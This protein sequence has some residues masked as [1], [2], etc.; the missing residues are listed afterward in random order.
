M[1]IVDGGATTVEE[2]TDVV[3]EPKPAKDVRES[4]GIDP[5]KIGFGDEKRNVRGNAV[6][7]PDFHD[8]GDEFGFVVKI[9]PLNCAGRKGIVLE[10]EESE[11]AELAVG[12]EVVD[13]TAGPGGMA[14]GVGPG[15]DVL[16]DASEDGAAELEFWINAM[17]CCGELYVE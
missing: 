13:E 7:A 5:G 3:A 6:F 8:A 10:R 11:F 14:A 17:E 4:F 2:G 9:A 1:E 12:L 16:I 15:F